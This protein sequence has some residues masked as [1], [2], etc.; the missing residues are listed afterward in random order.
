MK[1]SQALIDSAPAEER[2][3]AVR[4]K[5]GYLLPHHGLLALTA[6]A[7][8]EG[9]DACYTAL[10][11]GSRYLEQKDK[12]FVWLGILAVKEEFLA[13]QHV[14][15]FLEAGGLRSHIAL[16][17]RIAAFAHGASAFNFADR[18]WKGHVSEFDGREE[19]FKALNALISDE[20]IDTGLLHMAMAAIHTCIRNWTQLEWHIKWT[21]LADVPE[22]HLSEAMSYSMFTGSIPNFIEGCEVW[23]RMISNGEVKATEPFRQWASIEQNGPAK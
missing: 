19:Y 12:E 11:L 20:S 7:L 13:T 10:T 21:Y 16:S 17:V 9:Y 6:P 18:H 8:L 15:K 23:R 5:R 14:G 22:A 4:E 3:K 1:Q 2:L